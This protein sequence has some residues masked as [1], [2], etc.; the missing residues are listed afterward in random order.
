MGDAVARWQQTADAFDRRFGAIAGSQWSASTPCTEWTVRDL[1]D[2]ATA[3]QARFGGLIGLA[4]T[5]AADWPAVRHAMEVLLADRAVLDGHVAVPGLGDMAKEQV[6]D[7]CA[8]DLLLHTWDLAR[9]IGADEQLPPQLVDDCHAWLRQLPP[10]I[11]RSPGRYAP[12]T[13]AGDDADE[14]ARMLAF[15][16]RQV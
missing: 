11:L 10:E 12:E 9:A 1:V 5:E 3:V 15:A 8:F 6:L 7:I 13:V 14:Q 16:G 2:H 4:V